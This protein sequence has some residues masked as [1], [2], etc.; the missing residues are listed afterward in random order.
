M[1][2]KDSP[3]QATSATPSTTSY[4]LTITATANGRTV[5]EYVFAVPRFEDYERMVAGIAEALALFETDQIERRDD[6]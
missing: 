4:G 3:A 2:S 1:H 5:R 6:G